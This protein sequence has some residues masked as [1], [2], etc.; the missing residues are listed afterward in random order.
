VDETVDGYS[1][2][3]LNALSWEILRKQRA[4]S[5]AVESS[6]T[7]VVAVSDRSSAEVEEL[8]Q[9]LQTL[10]KQLADQQ[11]VPPYI[12]FA[13]ASLRE[14][15]QR[16]P[17]TLAQF[18]QIA[19]VGSRKLSQYGDAFTSEICAFRAEKNLPVLDQEVP[20]TK[21][22]SLPTSSPKSL[23][24]SLSDTYLYT[25]KLY[26]QGL[27]PAEIAE[28][29]NLRLTTIASHLAELIEL[30]YEI[31]LDPLVSPDRQ[32]KIVEAIQTVGSESRR[33][34]RDHLGEVYGYDEIHLVQA[35]WRRRNLF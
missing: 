8:Y 27:K 11:G 22:T 33:L 18:S 24:A 3:K 20:I 6:A 14:M 12:V 26:Q 5:I 15:A 30:G 7:E 25:W 2:L 34:I 35:W 31:A 32:Q 29:R 4:V 13:N 9:R 10:R 19:G 28:Q 23:S 1:V 21:I 17:Q 16:Q